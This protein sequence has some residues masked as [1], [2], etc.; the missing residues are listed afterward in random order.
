MKN[1]NKELL[2]MDNRPFSG[3]T[4]VYNEVIRDP[5]LDPKYKTLYFLL[6]SYCWNKDHCF[7]SQ[8][9]LARILGRDERTVRK[10]INKLVEYGLIRVTKGIRYSNVYMLCDMKDVYK[11]TMDSQDSKMSP[12]ETDRSHRT[13]T[14]G[15]TGS[16]CPP[17]NTQ[18]N[19]TQLKESSSTE[20]TTTED[21]KSNT[22]SKTNKL[23]DSKGREII[24][25]Y[26][27]DSSAYY[28]YPVQFEEFWEKYPKQT[29]KK[30]AYN[31]WEKL[32]FN[33]KFSPEDITK[34]AIKYQDFCQ[35]SG[36]QFKYI[37]QA[38]T[39]LGPEEH[40]IDYLNNQKPA[41]A[42]ENKNQA[43][44]NQSGVRKYD[45]ELAAAIMNKAAK[46][47]AKNNQKEADV[48]EK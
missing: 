24:K 8:K 43:H 46:K 17:N 42:S 38:A 47:A 27:E 31:R 45:D 40:W 2:T 26:R 32:V 35:Q 6:A 44:I 16:F 11:S 15:Q 20:S 18:S 3:F 4:S 37:K 13:K 34:S 41:G 23:K 22:N 21:D 29:S 19:N 14:S 48:N 9:Q 36:R 5:E 12:E 30:S 1:N 28:N 33:K 25:A 10:W 7:P 39:F